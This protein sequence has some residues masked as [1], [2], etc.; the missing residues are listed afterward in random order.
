MRAFGTGILG[1]GAGSQCPIAIPR[2]VSGQD[3]SRPCQTPPLGAL[4]LGCSR[5]ASARSTAANTSSIAALSGVSGRYWSRRNGKRSRQVQ[6]EAMA[7][8]MRRVS[9]G[10]VQIGQTH[11]FVI[12]SGS[13]SR[14][15]AYHI[16]LHGAG[17]RWPP[18]RQFT[19]LHIHHG[20]QPP[21][22][23]FQVKLPPW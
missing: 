19:A 7:A 22:G 6:S 1:M 14:G 9:M 16:D 3:S 2:S 12:C 10:R 18:D 11:M 15:T 23:L 20:G 5:T 8:S 4:A 21:A 13:E 17:D